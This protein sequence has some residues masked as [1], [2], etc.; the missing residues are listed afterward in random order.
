MERLRQFA[1]DTAGRVIQL[2]ALACG[3]RPRDSAVTK[4]RRWLRAARRMAAVV[5]SVYLLV[6]IFPEPLF[7][8]HL[9]RGNFQVHSEIPIDAHLI[10]ILDEAARLMERSSLNDPG[11]AHRLFLCNSSLKR[12]LLAPRTH[13]SFGTTYAVVFRRNTILNRTDVSANV[14]FRDAPTRNRRPLSSVIAHERVHALLDCRYGDLTCY[15]LPDWKKEGY[16]EY[17]AG[18]P[19]FDVDEGRRLIRGGEVDASAPFRYF[20]YWMMVKYLI[21]VEGLDIDEIIARDFNVDEVLAKVR[22]H[23][24]E[25]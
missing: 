20:R 22:R 15:R 13:A 12:R 2:C 8:Y 7:A 11:M 4:R 9:R 5:V 6:L 24:D 18:N 19:S 10:P 1:W 14:V 23:I 21:D 3:L 17:I 16:C 25:L